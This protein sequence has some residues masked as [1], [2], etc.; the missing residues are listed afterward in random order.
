MFT[1]VPPLAVYL[2]FCSCLWAVCLEPTC[3]PPV[4]SLFC[5]CIII[6]P[7][8]LSLELR[9]QPL[10]A[11]AVCVTVA[12]V[13]VVCAYDFISVEGFERCK[14]LTFTQCL[15][16]LHHPQVCSRVRLLNLHV[17]AQN[18]GVFFFRLRESTPANQE[19][20]TPSEK[21]RAETWS[22]FNLAPFAAADLL[23]P[24][25]NFN[26]A[27]H[28]QHAAAFSPGFKF[29]KGSCKN[30]F[31]RLS[32]S[33]GFWTFCMW[34]ARRKVAATRDTYSFAHTHIHL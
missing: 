28:Q 9:W 5:G 17:E 23:R 30:S 31:V 32:Y 16:L 14:R 25:K 13:A 12:F 27:Q 1:V 18:G 10:N 3:L 19:N 11:T 33:R 26:N 6:K 2:R 7:P 22:R 8:P 4:H 34:R 20:A 15:L 21:Q 29:I 24:N